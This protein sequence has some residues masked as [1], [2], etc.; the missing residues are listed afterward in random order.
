[1]NRKVTVVGSGN[2]GAT[3]A[4]RIATKELA[5]VVLLDIL[6]GVPQGKGLDMLEANP[7]EGS[8]ARVLGTNDYADTA[9]SDIVVITAGLA[10]KP[11]MSRDDLLAKN[12]TIIKSVTESVVAHSPECI[13]IP[14]TNPL[15]AMCQVVYKVSGFPRERVVGMAGIL[16]SARMRAFIAMELGVSVENTHAFVLGGHGDTM[17]PLPRYSTV[18][19]IPITELM[20]AATVEAIVKRT[21]GGGGEIVKLLGSGSAYYAPGSAVV[22]MVDAILKDKKKILPCAAF[23]QGE[24]GI[25]DLFVGVPVKLGARGMEEIIQITLTP[26]EQAALQKSADAVAELVEILQ[27]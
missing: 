12:K 11:G 14:V 10:R 17:V 1:M 6:E 7:V 16:D 4:R 5:D 22:E 23:L 3:A 18:A 13:I 24:Y 2:V 15:D 9:G 27:L 26:D 19:G 20:D 25:S 21:A 8:D